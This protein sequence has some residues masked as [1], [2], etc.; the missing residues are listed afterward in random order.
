MAP[1]A[2][3]VREICKSAFKILNSEAFAPARV[4]RFGAGNIISDCVVSKH[5]LTRTFGSYS[6]LQTGRPNWQLLFSFVLIL[7][8]CDPDYIYFGDIMVFCR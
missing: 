2:V 3:L 4:S 8:F 6:S 1:H 5:W 7:L